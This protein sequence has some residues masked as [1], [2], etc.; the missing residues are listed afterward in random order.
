MS[1][2]FPVSSPG[3]VASAFARLLRAMAMAAGA[4]LDIVADCRC[5]GGRE[6]IFGN[7]V[8]KVYHWLDRYVDMCILY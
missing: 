5:L 8:R 6:K 3:A 4:G 7:L 2:K 1:T